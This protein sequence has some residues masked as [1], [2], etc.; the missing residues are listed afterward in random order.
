MSKTVF[1]TKL[2]GL[3]A[4]LLLIPACGSPAGQEAQLVGKWSREQTMRDGTVIEIIE[5]FRSDYTYSLSMPTP[6]GERFKMNGKWQLEGDEI[7]ITPTDATGPEVF[8]KLVMEM[9]KS[10]IVQREKIEQLDE[11]QL[12][13]REY[14]TETNKW[15]T[16]SLT[17]KREEPGS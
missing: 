3:F 6:M 1:G 7:Q 13:L 8:V 15:D 17:F 2:V 16:S 5:E 12:V 4:L 10:E 14:D 11:S 9:V